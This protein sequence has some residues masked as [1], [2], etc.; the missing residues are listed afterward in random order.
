MGL[1]SQHGRVRLTPS[2]VPD[3]PNFEVKDSSFFK[4]W[5]GSP[6]PQQ[7]REKA[8][9][10]WAAGTSLDKRKVLSYCGRHMRPPLAV[11]EDMGLV[12]KW[13]VLVGIP[14]A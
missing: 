2:M 1:A 12:V 11:F 3:T 6:T 7:V 14:E 8:K 4:K 10:P 9:A 5:K 13:G